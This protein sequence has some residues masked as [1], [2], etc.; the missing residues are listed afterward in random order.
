MH[1]ERV[2]GICHHHNRIGV[3]KEILLAV[4][5]AASSVAVI[6]FTAALKAIERLIVLNQ[7]LIEAHPWIA[8]ILLRWDVS[9]TFDQRR[10][11]DGCEMSNRCRNQTPTAEICDRF[12]NKC[13]NFAFEMPLSDDPTDMGDGWQWELLC[14]TKWSHQWLFH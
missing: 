11:D 7:S 6:I 3:M 12:L 1:T 13:K 2:T 9:M 8:S 14:Y 5:T 10:L 4:A